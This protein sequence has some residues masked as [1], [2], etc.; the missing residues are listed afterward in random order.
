MQIIIII[1]DERERESERERGVKRSRR[2]KA[3]FVILFFVAI[4]FQVGRGIANFEDNFTM[5]L[6]ILPGFLHHEL[7][8]A[9]GR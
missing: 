3:E 8:W 5:G 6:E 9:D 1:I 7:S 4:L 2:P